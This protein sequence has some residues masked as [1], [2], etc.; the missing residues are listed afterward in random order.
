MMAKFISDKLEILANESRIGNK[1][2]KDISMPKGILIELANE[3]W[4][5]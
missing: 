2:F 3:I 1:Y 4:E 5:G